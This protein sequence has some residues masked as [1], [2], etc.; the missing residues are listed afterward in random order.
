MPGSIWFSILESN[1]FWLLNSDLKFV[2]MFSIFDINLRF[3]LVCVHE[4]A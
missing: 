4:N 2:M 1:L 3:F